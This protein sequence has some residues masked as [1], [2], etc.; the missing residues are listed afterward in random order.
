V[1]VNLL[2]IGEEFSE[3]NNGINP[4]AQELSKQLNIENL[5]NLNRSQDSRIVEYS[6]RIIGDYL[7][8]LVQ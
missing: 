5:E 1:L 3:R 7:D 2:R 6:Q 8:A 4:I